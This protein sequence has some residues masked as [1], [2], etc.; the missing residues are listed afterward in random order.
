MALAC[1]VVFVTTY[2]LILPAITLDKDS[3]KDKT[4]MSIKTEQEDV[5]KDADTPAVSDDSKSTGDV[6]DD[7]E[8]AGVS[9]QMQE[10]TV[11]DKTAGQGS[12]DKAA[13]G[14]GS[15]NKSTTDADN[16]ADNNKAADK[17]KSAAAA[18]QDLQFKGNDF[19]VVVKCDE[20]ANLPEGTKLKV[21]EIRKDSKDTAEQT[22][23]K[24]YYK[25]AT[26]AVRDEA[27]NK[28]KELKFARFFDISFETKDGKEIEP[29]SKVNVKI[30]YDKAVDM[31]KV[32][33]IKAVHFEEKLGVV[34]TELIKAD[35][36]VKNEKMTKA[37]FDAKKFSVY[38]LVGSEKTLETSVLT[39]EGK[40]Y[41]IKVTY[42][43][44]AGIPDEAELSAK[45][46]GQKSIEY[47]KYLKKSAKKLGLDDTKDISFARFF[48][49]EITKDGEKIEPKSAVKVSI[50][51]DDAF[52]LPTGSDLNVVHFASDGTELIEKVDLNKKKTELTYKQDSF[53]VTGTVVSGGPRN[54]Q[55]YMLIA[56]YE[57]KNYLINNDGT[58]IPVSDVDPTHIKT[59]N[60]M[61]WTY[62]YQYG[63]HFRFASEASGFNADQ[64]A[65]G[66]YYRYLDPNSETGLTEEDAQHPH[67]EGIT[68]INYNNNRVSS[69]S[70]NNMYIGISNEGGTLHV[71]GQNNSSHAAKITLY[72]ADQ[73]RPSDPANHTVNHIDISI[74]GSAQV[75]VPLAYGIY[76][77]KEGNEW[78]KIIVGR[79]VD[80]DD[81]S[82]PL[83]Q[84]YDN[85]TESLQAANVG[86]TADDMKKA[87]IVAK[88]KN[89]NEVDNAFYITGYSANETTAWSTDQVRIEGSFKVSTIDPVNWW[90]ANSEYTR[91][92][93]KANPITYTVEAKKELELPLTYTDESGKKHQLYQS[94]SDEEPMMINAQVPMSASFN[95]W[96]Y[97]HGVGNECPPLQPS[98]GYTQEWQDGGIHPWGIS[99]MDF[100]LKADVINV[101]ANIVALEISKK[102]VDEN[103]NVIDNISAPINTKFEVYRDKP[104]DPTT[105]REVGSEIHDY[106]T[107]AKLHDKTITV[108]TNGTGH[109]FDYD[110]THGMYYVR[111]SRDGLPSQITTT[112]GKT[113]NYIRT[114]IKTEYSYRANGYRVKDADGNTTHHQMHETA[115]S[116]P[117]ANLNSIP[118]VL[119]NYKDDQGNPEKNE[120]LEFYFYN[121]YSETET[122]PPPEPV[123]KTFN[124]ELDKNWQD[125]SNTEPPADGTVTFKLHQIQ[126]QNNSSQTDVAGSGYPKTIV[127]SAAEGWKATIPNLPWYETDTHHN[128][129]K[130]FKYYLEEDVSKATGSAADYGVP[131]FDNGFG[132]INKPVEGS[133]EDQTITVKA[134]NKTGNVIRI[135]KRWLNIDPETA[136]PVTI[137][138]WRQKLNQWGSD[139]GQPEL[140]RTITLTHDDIVRGENWWMQDIALPAER[141]EYTRWDG[142]K[143]YGDYAYF[144]SER[145]PDGTNNT[146]SDAYLNPRFFKLTGDQVIE[147]STAYSMVNPCDF[148]N[149]QWNKRRDE[150]WRYDEKDEHAYVKASEQ[151]DSTLIVM[152]APK[153]SFQ[154]VKLFKTW[155]KYNENGQLVQASSNDVN[156]YAVGLQV[157]Q[158]LK[159]DGA[160]WAPFARPFYIAVSRNVID[161]NG[162][163]YINEDNPFKFEYMQ[164]DNG[165]WKWQFLQY[166]G[167]R[168][169]FPRYGL[170]NGQK[171]EYEYEVREF[172]VYTGNHA[173]KASDLTRVYDYTNAQEWYFDEQ[174]K[175][176]QNNERARGVNV[177]AGKLKV[178]KQW[179]GGH[180]G[181]K[182]YFKVYR[183]E[184][185]I[186]SQIVD[187]PESYHLTEHQVV[188]GGTHK[189][190]I[191]K[192]DG[193]SWEEILIE[194]LPMAPAGGGTPY[195]YSIKE[196]GYSEADGTDCW[197]GEN[198]IESDGSMRQ[199]P[200]GSGP[201]VVHISDLL[202]GYVI[203]NAG[204]ETKINGQSAS[205]AVTGDNPH[206]IQVNNTY[207]EKYKN[208]EFKKVWE[209]SSGEFDTWPGSIASITVDLYAN[210]SKC[211]E[212]IEISPTPPQDP[213]SMVNKFTWNGITYRCEVNVDSSGKI[214]S[215]KIPNLPARNDDGEITYTVKETAITEYETKYGHI[216]EGIVVSGD[217]LVN[218]K[219]FEEENMDYAADGKVICNKKEEKQYEVEI[220]KVD[221]GNTSLKL[222]G[223]IFA[224]YADSSVENGNVKPGEQP[225]RDNLVTASTGADKG[226][227]SLGTLSE[228]T[229]YLLEK[230]APAGY[231][232]LDELIQIT[233][234][235]N[236]VGLLQGERSETVTIEQGQN[237]AA[238]TVMNSAGVELPHTGGIGTTVFYLAGVLM[239][240]GAAFAGV[241]RRRR[242]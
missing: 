231:E 214:Y 67:L 228:G 44:E 136:P 2:A 105:V 30:V 33:D 190:L 42:D 102:I 3:A 206:S 117:N 241:R 240:A 16:K 184:E 36:T 171:V 103:G 218:V 60:P 157:Y 177:A 8:N 222:G 100:V 37:G 139:D 179:Q 116:N 165:V 70:N 183:G 153:D 142:V 221:T 48:D 20:K 156:Q 173:S 134:T 85:H 120:F 49:I 160:E 101:P 163:T 64:T 191:V 115:I 51:Y 31:K 150:G 233:V 18:A 74:S 81:T 111:E 154:H 124:I 216:T 143:E 232:K 208:F 121:V 199:E 75:D 189:A 132:S 88:D 77:Y 229:Y 110:V 238:L 135:Q 155:F 66:F 41:T 193:T 148:G 7:S 91:H 122:P 47:R 166:D 27:G 219:T 127:L 182:I 203:D 196:I 220:V 239:M 46:I 12:E 237:K 168:N 130:T 204:N 4:G 194:G 19:K 133:E 119:G 43:E 212:G 113:Y 82:I 161:C 144:I 29:S 45:E 52:E 147:D 200:N 98:W 96:T 217:D 38:G 92:R 13:V 23:Y 39:A 34:K 230:Q 21:K 72:S 28:K 73:V 35:A 76:Y 131:S 129:E 15:E 80:D 65:S 63:A 149:V 169:G 32:D 175:D 22:L 159:Q 83:V 93:R 26:K 5:S 174:H 209:N 224:L 54:G 234:S 17:E 112:N 137:D 186:T 185:D 215:I 205:V 40:T 94:T 138:I 84:R 114:E 69:V 145:N 187:D 24:D 195:Q 68:Q 97:I 192:C 90:E 125:G 50:S 86:I 181:S 118:E 55:Q 162:Q 109:K 201:V 107:Y 207:V 123:E 176:A 14:N 172:G 167:I 25:K 95:Y 71:T 188:D 210:N 106:G 108:G 87:K 128:Y 99:G 164:D 151:K 104:G 225:I 53:S 59:D 180:T 62:Y 1:V 140:Y 226:K 227:V 236:I 197:D 141:P 242:A 10:K 79:N 89:G 235:A 170:V 152:N 78:K 56:E 146:S 213:Q 6:K 223:A 57:G 202:T 58:L 11:S 178:T 198:I 211:A 9:D 158:R 126:T 61:L